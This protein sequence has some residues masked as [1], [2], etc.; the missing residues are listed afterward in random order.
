MTEETENTEI[1]NETEV[2]YEEPESQDEG[3]DKQS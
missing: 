2:T 3:K 1:D